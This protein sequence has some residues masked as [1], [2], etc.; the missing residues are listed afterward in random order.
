V[1]TLIT[2]VEV[3]NVGVVADT[4]DTLHILALATYQLTVMKMFQQY[5]LNI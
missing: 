5:H 3:L 1:P 4:L 2:P